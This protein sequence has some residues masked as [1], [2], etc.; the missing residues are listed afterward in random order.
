[1]EAVFKRGLDIL[2]SGIAMICLSWLILII[3][4]LVRIN[5]GSPVIFK[6]DRPGKDGKIFKLYKFRSMSNE[7]DK[8]GNLL[9]AEKRLNRF[10]KILRSTS[11]DELPELYNIF[12]GDMSI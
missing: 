6:Q 4:L 1:Y 8:E 7:K 11:L 3:A 12:K 10:G 9:P 5:L 2:L